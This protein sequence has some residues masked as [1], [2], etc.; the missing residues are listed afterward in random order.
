LDGV[1]RKGC[2]GARVMVFM[3][4]V[5][6]FVDTELMETVVTSGVTVVAAGA[7]AGSVGVVDV[8]A[9]VLGVCSIIGT[10]GTGGAGSLGAN[11]E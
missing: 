5:D 2:V 7:G 8:A 1:S 11:K 9:C 4:E 10:G 6:V 3:V